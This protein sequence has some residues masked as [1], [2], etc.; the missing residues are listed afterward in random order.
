MDPSRERL[1]PFVA[2]S[3]SIPDW[4]VSNFH[5]RVVVFKCCLITCHETRTSGWKIYASK[6]NTAINLA[7]VRR[8]NYDR[9]MRCVRLRQE[10]LR[11]VRVTTFFRKWKKGTKKE[12]KKIKK[13]KENEQR[14]CVATA[15]RDE[16]EV[17]LFSLFFVAK[18]RRCT[19]TIYTNQRGSEKRDTHSYR[20]IPTSLAEGVP[21]IIY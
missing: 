2:N 7:R 5:F 21:L 9:F 4:K 16:I 1:D 19:C 14:E 20:N 18:D 13:K 3:R 6:I 8:E 12:N 11:D 10:P 15:L 17:F